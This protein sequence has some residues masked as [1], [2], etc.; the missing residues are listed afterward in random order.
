MKGVIVMAI[1]KCV[2]QYSYATDIKAIKEVAKRYQTARNYFYARYSGIKS[3]SKLKK[4]KKE[5]RDVL[6]KEKTCDMFG[7]QARQWKMALDEVIAN[8]KSAW[9]NVKNKMRVAITNNSNLSEEERH[10]LFYI[11]K[12]DEIFGHVMCRNEFEYPKGLL[13]IQVS[14]ERIPYL[15]NLLRRYGRKYKNNIPHSTGLK[16]FDIDA[17]MYS[18]LYK[19]GELYIEIMGLKRGER[20]TFKLKD[21]YRYSGNLTIIVDDRMNSIKIHRCLKV[22]NKGIE[23]S[24]EYI[25]GIDKGYT[26]MLSCS[27]G[28]EYGYGF[29]LLLTNRTKEINDKNK[30]RNKLWALAKKY[31]KEGNYEKASNII[32]NNLGYKKLDGRTRKFKA[33]VDS[34]INRTINEMLYDAKPTEVVKEDLTFVSK[35]KDSS[36]KEYN[37]KMYRWVK[38]RINKRLDYKCEYYQVKIK[39]V[40]PAYTSQICHKC[41]RFGYRE[42]QLFTCPCCGNMDANINASK[43]ILQRRDDKEITLYTNYTKV[44]EILLSRVPE[45]KLEMIENEDGQLMLAI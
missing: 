37:R 6:I 26:T 44:K 11:L 38:G 31:E 43:V 39:D 30:K 34:F 2:K 42:H 27:N 9:S 29:G 24:E 5:I 23:R 16:S 25:I 3:I 33:R 12:A 36:S 32:K 15:F 18:Y 13:D 14:S 35:K 21:H 41:G 22:E 28:K 17:D 7:L 40:N 45:D 20:I 10:F 4:Y 19:N 1:A 8:I